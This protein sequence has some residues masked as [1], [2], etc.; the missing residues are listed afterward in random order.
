V[1]SVIHEVHQLHQH[2]CPLQNHARHFIAPIH[3]LC[4]PSDIE[5]EMYWQGEISVS[6]LMNF[7]SSL[8]SSWSNLNNDILKISGNHII[9]VGRIEEEDA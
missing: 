8:L 7:W 1:I 2:P 5:I 3:D 4:Q 6:A 9:E